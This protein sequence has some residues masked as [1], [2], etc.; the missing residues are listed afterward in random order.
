[1][2][3]VIIMEDSTVYTIFESLPRMGAVLL[4]AQKE[5]RRTKC[6][7]EM[8]LPARRALW[9]F[10]RRSHDVPHGDGCGR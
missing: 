7:L 3:F 8:E 4:Q 5:Q 1:M 6:L 9:A 2:S 10:H